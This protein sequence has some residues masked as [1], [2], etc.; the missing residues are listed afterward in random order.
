MLDVLG[1]ILSVVFVIMV[2]IVMF[3]NVSG[4]SYYYSAAMT[5]GIILLLSAILSVID[6]TNPTAIDVYRN[7]TTLEITYRGNVPIDSTV[8]FKDKK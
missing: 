8:V 5:V 6:K 2:V 1:I 7:K 3:C 4:N